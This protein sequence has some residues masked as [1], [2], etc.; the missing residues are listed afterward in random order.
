MI[1][2]NYITRSVCELLADKVSGGYSLEVKNEDIPL[3]LNKDGKS[4]YPEIRLSPFISKR[5]IEYQKYIEKEYEA[6]R[7]WQYGAF[8]VDIYSKS[9]VQCQDIYDVITRRLY[10]F[11][12]LETVTF[13]YNNNFQFV[14]NNTYRSKEYSL[15]DDGLFKDIYGIRV[16]DVILDRV[17]F[18]KNLK[19]NSFFISKDYLY[20][21]TDRNIKNISMKFLTQGRLFGDGF[22][23]SDRGIHQYRITSQRN[24]SSLEDNEVERISFDLEVLYSKKLNRE[25][26][27][28]VKNVSLKKPY[29]R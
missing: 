13:D 26:L 10:D 28:R 12:N 16:E 27:P 15:M 6:Y 14:D 1:S 21:Q 19:M 24:L 5:D 4:M 3:L 22:S 2:T 25:T 29:V 7:H 11:F 8:Q 23:H 9:L 18:K 17:D 20:V